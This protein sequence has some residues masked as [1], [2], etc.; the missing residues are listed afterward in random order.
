MVSTE[1]GH[2]IWA[3]GVNGMLNRYENGQW[4]VDQ[5]I[6]VSVNALKYV[7][8]A[9]WI[10]TD[11]GLL[12]RHGTTV[13]AIPELGTEAVHALATHDGIL[14]AATERGLWRLAPATGNVML[15]EIYDE[16]G[17]R[18]E[19]P[20]LEVEVEQSDRLWIGTPDKVVE[21]SLDADHA[22]SYQPFSL[23]TGHP[24]ITSIVANPGHSV[25]AASEFG[26]AVEFGLA[27]DDITGARNWG[28]SA[29]GGLSTNSV[30]DVAIDGNGS[31]WFATAVGV[32][33]YQPW[34]WN[35]VDDRYE[36]LPVYDLLVDP[37]GDLWIATGGEGV[38]HRR[39]NSNQSVGYLPDE[40]GLAGEFVYDLA[41]GPSGQLWAA[42]NQGAAYLDHDH[43]RRDKALLSLSGTTVR[44]IAA[45]DLGAWLGTSTGLARY[46]YGEDTLQWEALTQDSGINVVEYDSIGRLWVAG[47]NASLWLLTADGKWRDMAAIQRDIPSSAAVTAFARLSDPPGAMIAAFRGF[48]IYRSDGLS[49]E[50]LDSG[51]KTTGE[52]V[53]TLMTDPGDGSIWIGSETGLSR[54]DDVGRTTYDTAD[55]IQ[56]GSVRAIT[57][58]QDGSYWFGGERGLAHYERETSIPWIRLDQVSGAEPGQDGSAWQAYADHPISLQFAF[59]DLQNNQ[60]KIAI[61]V[62]SMENGQ[63]GRWG[64]ASDGEYQLT[65]AQPGHH[66]FEFM[67][68]DQAF[69]YSPVTTVDMAA[70]PVPAM[71]AVP[72]L[73]QVEVK[74]F[75]LLILFGSLAIF[76]FGYVSF[77][78]IQHRRRIVDAVERGYNPYISGEPV[79]RGDMFFGRHDLLRRI[80]STLH[81]NSIMIHGERRIGKTTLLYQLANAL[82]Q[83]EDE[84]FWFVS[85]YIDL[86][87][88]TEEEFFHLLMDEIAHTVSELPG[89]TSEQSEVLNG[90]L[91]LQIAE[92]QYTDREF[93]RDLRQII[94][95]LESYGTVNHPDCQVRLILLMDEMDTLSRFNHLIQQQLRRIFMRD[96]AATLGAVVAG[97][98]ISK[99]W[100][101]IESPWFNLFNEIAMTPF[102]RD[103]AIELLTEPVRGYYLFEPD[104]LDFIVEHSDGR[105]YRLQQYALE[106]VNQMLHQK[107][108]VITLADALVAHE[109][110]QLSGQQPKSSLGTEAAREGHTAPHAPAAAT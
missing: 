3:A 95:I 94:H 45:D 69:N 90:L 108:R 24:L 89:L 26:G 4:T 84:E 27:G 38:Q 1:D 62:R 101:R 67:A 46:N 75:Q 22:Q 11:R 55:G 58:D 28:S 23:T 42:T 30:R 12:V 48:G 50:A 16:Y 56:A 41:Q 80:V 60:D 86:E 7:N 72:F 21:F 57:I 78:I 49:W 110:I 19:G 35:V 92:N 105:P 13:E 103:E 43:W 83:V 51:R 85:V 9:I 88:T 54:I 97:I 34:A 39:R 36:F 98:E 79:R 32:F 59:G 64:Q 73:G 77:E 102:T 53:F 81:N 106:A 96:F 17:L 87:G 99:E 91:S 71:I 29:G 18:L 100:E 5:R 8:G 37:A 68:R 74:I 31:V 47:S 14:W 109:L 20:L 66:T 44:S 6:G 15:M 33:R 40:S 70:I 10:A 104:A 61:F 93:N 82:Q 65:L 107:R 63:P 2:I 25:W 52:R 76:G